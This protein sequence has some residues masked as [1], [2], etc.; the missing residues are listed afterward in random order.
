MC[1]FVVGSEMAEVNPIL[2][3]A[4]VLARR[5]DRPSRCGSPAFIRN[6]HQIAQADQLFEMN[7]SDL[8]FISIDT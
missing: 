2:H 7:L 4:S 1:D 6:S 8:Y 5:T 3:R